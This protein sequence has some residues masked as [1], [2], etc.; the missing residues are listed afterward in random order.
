MNF[1]CAISI[2]ADIIL[3]LS[4]GFESEFIKMVLIT[5]KE[6]ALN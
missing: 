4:C 5:R 6:T 2:H 3:A 1:T